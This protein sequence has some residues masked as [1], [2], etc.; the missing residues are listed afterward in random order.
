MFS[1]SRLS[2]LGKSPMKLFRKKN[3]VDGSTK[4]D[5]LRPRPPP[6]PTTENVEVNKQE[7]KTCHWSTPDPKWI[8]VDEIRQWI[9]TCDSEH[10]ETCRP[11]NPHHTGRPIWLIDV[12]QNCLVP[13]EQHRYIALS[14]V[15]GG[16]DSAQTATDTIEH[17][18]RPGVLTNEEEGGSLVIPKT[19]LHT[20]GLV[21]TLGERYLWV[22]RFCICQDDASTKHAQLESMADIY[23]NAYLTIVAASEWDANHGL[24]GI[25]GITK[26]RDLSSYLTTDQYREFMRVENSIWAPFQS[27]RGW[28]F[29]EMVFSR[30]K[31]L[32]QYQMVR[33]EC[34]FGGWHE[35]TGVTGHIPGENIKG[36]SSQKFSNGNNLVL[37][38]LSAE[39]T[40]NRYYRLVERYNIRNLSYPEDGL[41]AYLGVIKRFSEVVPGGFFWGLPISSL[42]SALLWQPQETLVRRLSR[43]DE[44]AAPKLPS[45]SW[46]GWQGS[47]NTDDCALHNHYVSNTEPLCVWKAMD[48][49]RRIQPLVIGVEPGG[50]DSNAT[51][52]E[53]PFLY[54]HASTAHAWISKP[55]IW[56]KNRAVN[57][58][59][60]IM[61][62]IRNKMAL[63]SR[64]NITL[65]FPSPTSPEESYAVDACGVL[66]LSPGFSLRSPTPLECELLAISTTEIKT[67]YDH[68]RTGWL[69]YHNVLWIGRRD[70]G[71]LYRKGLGFVPVDDWD[72]LDHKKEDVVLG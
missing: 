31:L 34:C 2:R 9:Y 54:A 51:L 70:D 5:G 40:L 58:N 49:S 46:V 44:T 48:K 47:V 39:S 23:G 11:T 29:Q 60:H 71:T 26:P 3:D 24:R 57:T 55:M 7:E 30:R 20:M 8:N 13:A 56:D 62:A 17:M 65:V 69:R 32:F 12:K 25:E 21:K 22:D 64:P 15:W 37:E 28:T 18:Q 33:W 68:D 59:E 72:R 66:F 4:S 1:K 63:Q 14:Y 41:R 67:W 50:G 16:V 43:Y 42:H 19:I 36:T 53:S 35:S 27:S 6:C 45:W 10:G 52:H 61:E 38:G